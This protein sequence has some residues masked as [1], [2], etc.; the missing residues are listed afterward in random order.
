[1]PIANQRRSLGRS[2]QGRAG[3]FA[4]GTGPFNARLWSIHHAARKKK[5]SQHACLARA[6]GQETNTY[7]RALPR[8]GRWPMDACSWETWNVVN[9]TTRGCRAMNGDSYRLDFGTKW[10]C[11]AVTFPVVVAVRGTAGSQVVVGRARR[12]SPGPARRGVCWLVAALAGAGRGRGG[13]WPRCGLALGSLFRQASPRRCTEAVS[14]LSSAFDM[15][16]T[17][18]TAMGHASSSRNQS[19]RQLD[20]HTKRCDRSAGCCCHPPCPL[21]RESDRQRTRP[22]L[23]DAAGT[24]DQDNFSCTVHI[25]CL[26]TLRGRWIRC[27]RASDMGY[28]GCG[29]WDQPPCTIIVYYYEQATWIIHTYQQHVLSPWGQRRATCTVL[30]SWLLCNGV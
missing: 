7:T 15:A 1:M 17:L 20:L 9:A 12:P 30:G 2:R 19:A 24:W 13:G 16:R 18:H 26:V 27:R 25:W 11:F 14:G 3:A 23:W 22:F 10:I 29:M 5:N 28:T 6:N 4:L 21:A 8:P